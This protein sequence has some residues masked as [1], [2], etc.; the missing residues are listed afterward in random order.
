MKLS[1][2]IST[3]NQTGALVKVLRALQGQT[4]WPD[5]VLIADDGS[6]EPTRQLIDGWKPRSS[7]QVQHIWHSDV[8]FR[9]TTILNKAVAAAQGDYV[10]LLDGDCVPHARF[11][12]DH[13]SVAERGFWVQGRRCFVLERFVAEFEPEQTPIWQ[14]MLAGRI[15]G[16]T[17]GVRLPFPL[18]FRNCKQRGILGCNMGFWRDDLVLINGFDEGYTG[19][20]IG[21]DSDV[22][23]RLYHLGRLRKFVYGHAII[24]HL[25]HPVMPRD[26]FPTSRAR[27]QETQHSRKVRCECGLDKYLV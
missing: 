1:L 6:G 27:L 13:V 19:W 3:Y 11:I 15:T 18:V 16:A 22:G 12:E 4:R 21:E 5:E 26:H 10:V 7:T 8:G 17:K 24:Y 23:T 14:W 9:K 2:I 25:N 20:G